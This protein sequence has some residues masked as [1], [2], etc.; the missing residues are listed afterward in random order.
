MWKVH[1]IH[2]SA[3]IIKASWNPALLVCVALSM[4]DFTQQCQI[5]VVVTEKVRLQSLKYLLS[6]FW[7]KRFADL[8]SQ[9]M[10]HVWTLMVVKPALKGEPRSR[11]A[12]AGLG[13][14]LSFPS[15]LGGREHRRRCMMERLKIVS[16][17][18]LHAQEKPIFLSSHPAINS[19][20]NLVSDNCIQK[21]FCS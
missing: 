21:E 1:E 10:E 17:D 15:W 12:V 5:C 19:W 14:V 4:A 9:G 6:D 18:C 20:Q 8:R 13:W 11:A 3:S 16:E 2:I 7:Q